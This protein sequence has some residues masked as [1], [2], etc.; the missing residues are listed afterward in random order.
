MPVEGNTQPYGLLHGGASV[1]L[2]ET[3][4]SIG[5]AIHAFPDKIAVGVDINATHHRSAT[6]GTV[7]GMA[8]ADP[9]RA[10]AWRPSRS[11][12]PTR[13]A[14][15]CARR[16]SPARSSTSPS[17]R[18][19]RRL[20]WRRAR[21]RSRRA[22]STRSIWRE[23][24]LRVVERRADS[25]ARTADVVAARRVACGVER[26]P[27][28]EPVG[29]AR[30]GHGGG[31]HGADPLGL[32]EPGRGSISAVPTPRRRN[33]GSTCGE[34]ASTA[35]SRLSGVRV[36]ASRRTAPATWPSNSATTMQRSSRSAHSAI[37][38]RQVGLLLGGGAATQDVASTAHAAPVRP[39][40]RLRAPGPMSGSCSH[41][42][43]SA[44]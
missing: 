33:S 14:S 8:T 36:V 40:P 23:P 12:S 21:G 34:T 4:G 26:E 29:V 32:G 37:T 18:L 20:S 44:P 39:R 2:A 15:G 31:G 25:L 27:R 41:S 35:G 17:G 11:S 3:L 16:A 28:H 1:V 24:R 30:A 38:R 10:A 5:S 19:S 13:R 43:G 7:T 22:A 42:Q 6:S 9:P